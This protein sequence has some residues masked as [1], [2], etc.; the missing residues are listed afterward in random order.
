MF[1]NSIPRTEKEE[2]E[3]SRLLIHSTT[4]GFLPLYDMHSPF[5]FLFTAQRCLLP[6]PKEGEEEGRSAKTQDQSKA[7]IKRKRESDR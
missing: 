7:K 2:E 3:V 1:T 6:N 5:S 4:R